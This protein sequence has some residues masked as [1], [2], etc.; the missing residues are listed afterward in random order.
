MPPKRKLGP[1]TPRLGAL[2]QAIERFRRKAKLC[3]EELGGRS[4]I[5]PTHVRGLEQGVRNPTY[6]T[7]VQLAE[8][9]GITVGKLP[10][11]ADEIYE[12]LPEAKRG[13]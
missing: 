5:H 1:R 7:L 4:G 12:Q 13:S 11:A 10:T 3:Q 8:G 9:L 2:G 6:K